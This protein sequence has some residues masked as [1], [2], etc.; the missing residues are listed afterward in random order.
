M[1]T[2]ME[3]WLTHIEPA[4][5]ANPR[6]S[7]PRQQ[8]HTDLT[9]TPFSSRPMPTT[10]NRPP[11][12]TMEKGTHSC[13]GCGQNFVV[14]I[15]P[16]TGKWWGTTGLC[17]HLRPQLRKDYDGVVCLRYYRANGLYNTNKRT[18]PL[19]GNI[20]KHSKRPRVDVAFAPMHGLAN[21]PNCPGPD[22]TNR[23]VTALLDSAE[24]NQLTIHDLGQP[25]ISRAMC[26][27]SPL[28]PTETC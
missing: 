23:G 12:H 3:H 24:A 25:P 7:L 5:R 18:P 26:Q 8:A 14:D 2:Q 21:M 20:S 27:M 6:S 1:L 17:K 28:T 16:R 11:S 15:D 10:K 4:S 13:F 9:K 22:A 19:Y